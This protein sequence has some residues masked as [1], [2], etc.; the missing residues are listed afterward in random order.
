MT[1][2]ASSASHA[3]AAVKYERGKISAPMMPTIQ[4]D[5]W[6][7]NFLPTLIMLGASVGMHFIAKTI[8]HVKPALIKT[9]A[10]VAV[11]VAGVSVFLTFT[12]GIVV[13]Y[14][15]DTFKYSF[16]R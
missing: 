8:V 11:C 16:R 12:E 10:I 6:L 2:Q 3:K 5:L 9:M 7:S 4:G 14:I 13:T 1:T 15:I